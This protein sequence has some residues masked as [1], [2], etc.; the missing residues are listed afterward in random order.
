MALT[1]KFVF[2]FD[3]VSVRCGLYELIVVYNLHYYND[4]KTLYQTNV[5]A[6]L[7]ISTE[8]NL[9]LRELLTRVSS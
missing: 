1:D 8:K 9:I 6:E 2:A 5:A 7:L 4:N 3:L